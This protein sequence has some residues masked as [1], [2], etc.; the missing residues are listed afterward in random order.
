MN[1]FVSNVFLHLI[2]IL[3][4]ATVGA[5]TG[6]VGVRMGWPLPVVVAVAAVAGWLSCYAAVQSFYRRA[7]LEPMPKSRPEPTPADEDVDDV[8]LVDAPEARADVEL[9]R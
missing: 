2:E 7:G 9:A 5:I 8:E 1:Q 6:L 3:A 4:G